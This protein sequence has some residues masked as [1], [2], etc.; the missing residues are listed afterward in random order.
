MNNRTFQL[1]IFLAQVLG[2]VS[3]SSAFADNITITQQPLISI[4]R[5][6]APNVVLA[7]SVEY[8]TA[9]MAYPASNKLQPNAMK[10]RYR[11]YFDNKKCYKYKYEN[12]YFQPTSW[13]KDENGYF[14]LCNS[15]GVTNEFSGNAL[16]F[17]TMTAID[18]FRS[19]MTGGNRARGT[20][21]KLS[22]YQ[23]ADTESDTY[24]RRARIQENIN[25]FTKTITGFS[26]SLLQRIVPSDYVKSESLEFKNDKAFSTILEYTANNGT[27]KTIELNPVIKVCVP[28]L[29]EDNCV[30]YGNNYKPEG[31]LQKY[32]RENMRVAAMGYLLNNNTYGSGGVLRARMKD[33]TKLQKIELNSKEYEL[34]PEW[35]LQTGIFAINPDVTDASQSAAPAVTNSGVINYLNKFGDVN[36][37]KSLDPGAE[38]YYT[39]LR[40]LRNGA[41]T[42]TNER[43]RTPAAPYKPTWSIGEQEGD[44]FPAIYDWE[45][46]LQVNGSSNEKQCRQNSIIFIGDTNTHHDRKLPYFESNH[47]TSIQDNI[48]TRSYLEKLLAFE[49]INIPW[50]RSIGAINSPGG[51]AG[52]AYWARIHDIRPDID[53]NQFSSNFMIDVVE[54]N[55]YKGGSRSQVTN[56]F[57]LAAKYGG[58]DTSYGDNPNSN[59]NSWTD[60]AK[61]TTSISAFLDGVP[62]NFAVAYDPE[63]MASA[64]E[65]AFATVNA[66][67][68]T[69]QAAPSFNS[70]SREVNLKDGILTLQS[71]YTTDKWTGNVYASEMKLVNNRITSATKWDAAS[72]LNSTYHNNNWQNRNIW[73]ADGSRLSGSLGSLNA[74]ILGDTSKEGTTY[75]KRSSLLGTVIYS[76]VVPILPP[77]ANR[78]RC[79]YKANIQNR[80]PAYAFAANDG[81]LHLLNQNGHEYWAYLPSTVTEDK[82]KDYATPAPAYVHKFLN[83][84]TPV[85]A[86]LCDGNITKSYL[87]GTTGRGGKAVYAFDVTNPS[88]PHQL[89]ELT[90]DSDS[91]LGLT[92]SEPVLTNDRNGNPIAI[93]SSGY[94]SG[95]SKGYLYIKSLKSG[96]NMVQKVALGNSNVGA[97]YGYDEDHDGIVDRVYV[98]DHDG[99]VWR[100][101][102]D[103]LGHWAIPSTLSS[104]GNPMP[105]FTADRPIMGAPYAQ[106]IRGTTYV[107]VGTGE[108]FSADDLATD[109]QNY[110]YGLFDNGM[111]IDSSKLL[112]QRINTVS[113]VTNGSISY[114]GISKNPLTAAHQGWRLELLKGQ[115]ISSAASIFK[116]RLANFYALKISASLDV[117]DQES[118]STAF[119]SVDI[120]D[121]GLYKKAPIFDT[122]RDG[123]F[124]P[125]DGYHGMAEI[126]GVLTPSGSRI[127]NMAVIAV[128]EGKI[129]PIEFNPFTNSSTFSRLS[130]REIRLGYTATD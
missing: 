116:S 26:P 14:G 121:G 91:D 53:G 59:R 87:V 100:V 85:T 62:R 72:W 18:I 23:D 30:K 126:S 55:N 40:Y 13:A 84:G 9:R 66:N 119:I 80:Q 65:K 20:N 1:S 107:V 6:Y 117:C 46:P 24:L 110:A 64:L 35:D 111:P 38:L 104:S 29:L 67:K 15:D 10:T 89:W 60:D 19:T 71:S 45:D 34:N 114:Y 37:Y 96:S 77:T 2:T 86:E 33:L 70:S 103:G 106:K 88:N 58:F 92:V 75:R 68:V 43:V 63:K 108:Y 54:N 90:G 56:A 12:G 82:L 44:G 122:N 8:P 42:A 11:G 120:T 22:N 129:V 32:G 4:S 112:D 98:G 118:G 95:A 127:G 25:N 61:D 124:M 93:F 69:S 109:E 113:D 41:W 78:A 101:D 128:G 83:D 105:L 73:K 31:L 74:Y 36:G 50:D 130:W 49:G 27:K 52:L 7:L 76:G 5:Q 48:E 16:N 97:P 102:H 99:K 125:N 94:N 51:I 57:Y 115:N 28:N 123:E 47:N 39:A 21:V 3:F 17:L 81:L 79:N